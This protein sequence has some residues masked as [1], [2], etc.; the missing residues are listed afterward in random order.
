MSV[1]FSYQTQKK[2]NT[3]DENSKTSI[4]KK[5]PVEK[6]N[7][8]F[9]DKINDWLLKFS[10]VPLK[11]RLFFVQ[12]LGI[13]LKAGISLSTALKTLSEQ[14]KNKYFVK[15]LIDVSADVEKGDTFA[16]SLRQ[17]QKVFGELFI[18]MIEAGELSGKLEEV[19]KQLFIQMKK[20]NK[21]ISKVKGALTYPAVIVFAMFGIGTFM[22]IFV[23]PK[24]TAMFTELEVELPLPTK[25]L[26]FVSDSIVNNGVISAIVFIATIFIFIRILKTKNG[27]IFFQGL[28]LMSPIIGPIVKKINLA[29]FARNISSLLKTDIMIIKTFQ[30]TANVLGNL[31][32][33]NALNVMSQKIKKGE[34]LNEVIK[35]YPKLFTPV[36]AQMVAIGEETGELDNI[37]VELA[38]FYEEEIDQIME[39]LPAIIEPLLILALGL[40][41]GGVA[42]AVIMPMYTITS[43]M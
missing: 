25:I 43:A 22:L 39:N 38:E 28:L 34:K 13:M 1:S 5:S 26:I 30:I 19:L 7:N 15:I 8:S 37:L 40:G 2:E 23:V 11:E 16:D 29:R 3:E 36:V 12:H 42:V 9:T 20:E 41:V 27:K 35:D 10:R 6:N 4:P 31:H 33:R 21:L 32:Y 17:Y 14:T 18:S 24:I